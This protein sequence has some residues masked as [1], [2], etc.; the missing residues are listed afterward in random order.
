MRETLTQGGY[1]TADTE[2]SRHHFGKRHT[3]DINLTVVVD[4]GTG[5]WVGVPG[6]IVH[7]GITCRYHTAWWARSGGACS[8]PGSK[9]CCVLRRVLVDCV[10]P[11]RTS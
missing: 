6:E 7:P 5:L 8:V 10:Y 4:V 9:C 1:F 3:E 11:R 2:R